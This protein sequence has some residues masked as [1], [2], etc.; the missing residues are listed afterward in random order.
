VT[1]KA[2]G[3]DRAVGG[4]LRNRRI[5]IVKAIMQKHGLSLIATSKYAKERKLY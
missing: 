4:G 2:E 5:A 1:V 3:A